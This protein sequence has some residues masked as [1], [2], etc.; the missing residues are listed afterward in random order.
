MCSE[1]SGVSVDSPAPHTGPSTQ[2]MN[3]A[4]YLDRG[5][6]ALPKLFP[7]GWPVPSPG[8]RHTVSWASV[9]WGLLH[10][11]EQDKVSRRAKVWAGEQ[12]C[13]GFPEEGR[14]SCLDYL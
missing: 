3:S 13:L 11:Q 4:A 8:G 5:V 6:S 14:H 7:S 12:G 10:E 2:Q 9:S 1:S